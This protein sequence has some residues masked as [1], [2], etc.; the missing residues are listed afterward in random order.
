MRPAYRRSH[1]IAWTCQIGEPDSK[2]PA[3]RSDPFPRPPA[4]VTARLDRAFADPDRRGI[5]G[6]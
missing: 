4:Y 6:T 1:G 2:P 3:D 5:L